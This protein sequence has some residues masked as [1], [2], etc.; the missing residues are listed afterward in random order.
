MRETPDPGLNWPTWANPMRKSEKLDYTSEIYI[1]T[2]LA[3]KSVW[4]TSSRGP[5]YTETAITSW[6]EISDN[7]SSEHTKIDGRGDFRV[8]WVQLSYC[9]TPR[10]RSK[11]LTVDLQR[12]AS[13]SQLRFISADVWS[14]TPPVNND[15]LNKY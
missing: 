5:S 2:V 4:R 8:P 1:V 12:K 11:D 7:V 14:C 13:R 15:S 10:D 9:E 3:E 6:M